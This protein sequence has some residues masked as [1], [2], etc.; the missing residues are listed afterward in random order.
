MASSTI[1]WGTGTGNIYLTYTG[2]G[3]GSI[4]VTSDP[5]PLPITRVQTLVVRCPDYPFPSVVLNVW[6]AP[7]SKVLQASFDDSFDLSYEKGVVIPTEYTARLVPSTYTASNASYV[8]VSNA[9]NM[10]NNTDH[11]SN[12]ASIRGR[13]GR[14]SNSTYYCFIRGFNFSAIPDGATIKSF[15]V[16]IR[17]YRNTYES[18]GSSYR[19]RLAS[20]A[21]SS[22]V[23]SGTTT[24]TDI[25]TTASVIEIP[26]GSMT[27]ATL[28][29]YGADL[30]IEVL[31]RNTSTS[32]SQYPYVYVYGAE[33]EVKY[34]I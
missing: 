11:T 14:S 17:C 34:E 12:Y 23:I 32:S 2:A 10:Y 30:S 5:N 25:D 33:I 26:T 27:W 1:P 3:N 20:Q 16:L 6:Q 31:L 24:S 4:S 28:K 22:R 19:L 21:S 29:G 18:T 15:R 9:S 13:G 7:G 8:S